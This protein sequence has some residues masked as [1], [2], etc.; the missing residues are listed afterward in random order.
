M[1][2]RMR[3]RM[4]RAIRDTFN[5][6]PTHPM[7]VPPTHHTHTYLLDVTTDEAPLCSRLPPCYSL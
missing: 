7:N 1:E 6:H 4:R 5:I 3:M 2:M